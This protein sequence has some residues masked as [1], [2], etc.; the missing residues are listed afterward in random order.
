MLPRRPCA[1]SV[2]SA[3]IVSDDQRLP[4]T[5]RDVSADERSREHQSEVCNQLHASCSVHG[6]GHLAVFFVSQLEN[7][8]SLTA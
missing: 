1:C 6:A 8:L 5:M 4:H 3:T 7:G 2:F